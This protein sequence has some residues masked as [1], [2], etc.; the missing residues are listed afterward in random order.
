MIFTKW[1]KYMN[2]F[3][4]VLLTILALFLS[5]CSQKVTIKALHPAEIHRVSSTKMISI[6]PFKND[7]VN[8]SGKI[9]T[10]LAQ[11]RLDGE[12]YFTIISRKDFN[13]IIKEQKIQNSGL[14][15]QNTAVEVGNL[16][17]AQAIV[18]GDVGRVSSSDTKYYENRFRCAD[19]KCKETVIYRVRCTK[20]TV[21]LTADMRIVDVVR[22]DIIYADTMRRNQVYRHCSDDSN[23]LP[24]KDMVAQK[25]AI[26]IADSFTYKLLPHYKHFEVVLL[27]EAD[28]D[29]TDKQEE[30]LEF[31]LKYIEQAR[32]DKAQQLL[33]QLI[34][35]TAQQSYVPFYNLGVLKEVE[36]NY[37]EAKEYYEMADRLMVK[38]VEEIS[39]AYNRIKSLIKKREQAYMQIKRGQ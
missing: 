33:F 10:K 34:D 29:Y 24:S 38:P 28:L 18:S 5:A 14:I 13:K 11:H 39:K 23:P 1:G 37:E 9:E 35:S 17:G 30:L 12:K 20:R 19:K 36:G 4:L 7:R 8:L 3:F 2:K 31:S 16:I 21:G 6:A 27:E 26:S 15:D 32:Y 22:G 25:L